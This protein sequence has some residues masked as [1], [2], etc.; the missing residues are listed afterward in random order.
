MIPH[1]RQHYNREF[2]NEKYQAFLK[3]VAE[4]YGEA[5]EFRVGESPIFVPEDLEKKLLKACDD[6]THVICDP[7]FDKKAHKAIKLPE[8]VVP[9]QKHHSLFLQFDFAICL[10]ENGN[11][12]PQLIELQGFP[13]LYF[14]QHLLAESYRKHF[15]IP[16]NY[17]HLFSGL[18]GDSY[19]QLLSRAILNGHHPRN[20][21]L[22]EIEPHLQNTRIDFWGAQQVFDIKILC[23]KDLKRSGKSLYYI[24]ERGKKVPIYRI[25]NRVIF[26]ELLQRPD[27][28]REFSFRD[29][30]D[31]EWAGHPNWF[32]KISKYTMP[33]LHSDFVPPSYFLNELQSQP[34]D[35][36]NYV[37]KP[38]F[39]FSGDGVKIDLKKSD[40]D[41][42]EHPED[43]I[44]QHKINYAPIIE[45]TNPL[46]PAKCELRMM[47][48]WKE[49]ALE[50]ILVNNLV[51]LTKGAMVGV[52]HNKNKDWVGASV[53]FFKV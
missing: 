33:S 48:I 15:D 20:V 14:F 37:L 5:P 10:D 34:D 30:V 46:E 13:S 49:D 25:F 7:E 35:L 23:L 53:G 22:L 3:T 4:A 2:T 31:V 1:I 50:P 21:V 24:D 40:L 11:Y 9:D 45:T 19:F 39:S 6:I 18:D 16:K 42:I 27:I 36:E 44:L 28:K 47:M 8:L 32:M 26:D 52:K 51:R 43:F 38:L 17:H 29:E 12:T 41:Q